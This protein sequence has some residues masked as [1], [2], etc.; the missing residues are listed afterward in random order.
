MTKDDYISWCNNPVTDEFLEI[1]LEEMDGIIAYLTDNAGKDPLQ[2][3]YRCGIVQG[4]K[5]LAEWKP[6]FDREPVEETE[7]DES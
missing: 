4:L 2:D 5:A 3:R 6:M 1:V 7:E